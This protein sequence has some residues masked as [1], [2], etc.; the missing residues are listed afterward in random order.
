MES[1]GSLL[2]QSEDVFVSQQSSATSTS[3]DDSSLADD[4]G[5]SKN[6][7]KLSPGASSQLDHQQGVCCI[8]V[9]MTYYIFFTLPCRYKME[10]KAGT[11]GQVN[12][13]HFLHKS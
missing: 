2:D 12:T 10:E 6:D 3:A 7:L 13:S 1:Q 9:N 8:A 5:G 11:D 4:V